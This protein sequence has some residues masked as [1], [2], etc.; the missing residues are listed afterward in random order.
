MDERDGRQGA[1]KKKVVLTAFGSYGDINP[2]VALALGLE[3][4]GFEIVLA[5]SETYRRKIESEGLAFCAVRPSLEQMLRDTGL[6]PADLAR[7]LMTKDLEFMIETT[8]T[9]YLDQAFADL[10]E[11]MAGADLVVAST[12]DLAGRLVSEKL[13][14]PLVS[15]LLSPMLFYSPDDPPC[16]IDI[17]WLPLVRATLGRGVTKFFM[18]MIRARVRQMLH[19]VNELRATIGLPATERVELLDG[20]LRGVIIAGLYSP[21]FAKLPADS[22]SQSF[23]AG[24][25]FYDKRQGGEIALPAGLET[26]LN[27]GS[28][29]IVFTLGTMVAHDPAHFY[30][31]SIEAARTLGRRSILLVAPELAD[32][33]AAKHAAEDVYVAGYVPYS[34]VFSR[35]S[36][37]VHH[38]G[39]G[40][41]AQAMRAGRPQLICPLLGDQVDNAQRL[42]RLGIGKRV[43]LTKYTAARAAA[44][45]RELVDEGGRPAALAARLAPKIAVEDGVAA[46]LAK[47]LALAQMQSG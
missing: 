47:I 13:D 25:A 41:I 34:L 46:L 5:S 2:F 15:V 45:L 16:F 38:G 17:Q 35:A 44:A 1:R 26:F 27:A 23:I 8:I 21:L 22:P 39:I 29:P 30:E 9:P 43:D 12:L 28:P 42:R 14:I 24:F 3:A 7:K 31:S 11:I 18:D 33:I 19:R 20:L 37:I 10:K 6:N 40:T 36:V 4:E 32:A